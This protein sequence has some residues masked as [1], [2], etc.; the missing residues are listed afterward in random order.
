MR[1]S[2]CISFGLSV[3]VVLWVPGSSHAQWPYPYPPYY[4]GWGYGPWS[5]RADAIAATGQLMINQEQARTERENTKQA[6]LQTQ[7][8]AFDQALYEKDIAR[9]YVEDQIIVQE[10]VI[11]QML[12]Q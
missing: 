2:V 10:T 6:R 4:P 3:F 1:K 8:M 7:K 5:G 12:S 9:R 11:T